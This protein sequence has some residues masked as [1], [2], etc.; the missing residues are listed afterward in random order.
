ML[1]ANPYNPH[2][3]NQAIPPKMAAILRM[4]GKGDATSS[5]A[6]V[7]IAFEVSSAH[8]LPLHA[9]LLNYLNFIIISLYLPVIFTI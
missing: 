6:T 3:E 8:K 7:D 4:S 1:P 5:K 2:A 9:K